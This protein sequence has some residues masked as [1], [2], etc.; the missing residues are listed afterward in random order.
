MIIGNSI[1]GGVNKKGMQNIRNKDVKVKCHPGATTDDLIDHLNP[2]LRKNPDIIIIHGGTND[3]CDE[4]DTVKNLADIASK[5]RKD[6]P[7]TKLVISNI[8]M[9]RDKQLKDPTGKVSLLN[10]NIGNLCFEQN[11]DQI[12]HQNIKEDHLSPRKLHLNKAGSSML[13][14]KFL[15]F[16][17]KL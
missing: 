5:I 1:I 4:V 13:A 7:K 9:R 3:L 14:K 6:H 12:K 15:D 11:L 8:T 16:I 10:R 2:V 17:D